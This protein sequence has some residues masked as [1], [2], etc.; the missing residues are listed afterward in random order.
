MIAN[1]CDDFRDYPAC[2]SHIDLYNMRMY[3]VSDISAALKPACLSVVLLLGGALAAA[4]TDVTAAA[5]AARALPRLPVEESYAFQKTLAAGVEP[6]RRDPAARP[7]PAEIEIAPQGWTLAVAA[8]AGPLLRQAADE[9]QDQLAGGMKVLLERRSLDSLEG[10]SA[11]PRAIV[12]GTRAQMPGCGA[13][14]TGPKD[15]QIRVSGQTV[16]VCGFDER[17]AM[18]GLYNL[19]ARFSLREAP[20]L[21]RDLNITRRSL[22]RARMTLSGLGWMEWPD[23]YLATLARYGFDS[24]HASIYRNPNNAPGVGPHW[25]HMKAHPPGAMKDLI[26]R[27]AKYGIDLYVPILWRY[28]PTPENEQGLRQLVR[29]LVGE[30]PEIRGYVLLTEGFYYERWF[31]A[32]GHGGEDLRKWLREWAHAVGIVTEECRRLNPA[33]EVLP[34]EYNVDFRPEQAGTKRYGTAQLPRDSIPLLTFENGK[35]FELDGEWITSGAIPPSTHS[36]AG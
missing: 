18:Y 30:F 20:Y 23:R 35:S 17:G 26:R 10:W 31:G 33:I 24:I 34:W 29:D 2:I 9:F 22:Y 4:E 36:A 25:D 32:G 19:E 14:F 16:A 12:A 1:K 13:A 15:Y 28:A 3:A 27:A 11:L 6:L 7:T 5:F 21:P 8:G